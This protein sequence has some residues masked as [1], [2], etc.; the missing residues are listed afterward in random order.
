MLV[1]LLKNILNFESYKKYFTDILKIL[2]NFSVPYLLFRISIFTSGNILND[3]QVGEYKQFTWI[4]DFILGKDTIY[5]GITTGWYCQKIPN[6]LLCYFIDNIKTIIY[7]S[8]IIILI[9][10]LRKDANLSKLSFDKFR[11]I[12]LNFLLFYLFWM[13]IG[14]YPPVRFSFYSIG[15][16]VIILFT[17]LFFSMSDRYVKNTSLLIYSYFFLLINHW[18]SPKILEFT[19]INTVVLVFLFGF[20]F[21]KSRNFKIFSK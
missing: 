19:I 6:F 17:T 21:F 18:N 20:L 3:N 4:L 14:W 9:L 7:L 2:S 16:L 10:I 11:P 8:T 1:I 15:N 13:F 5:S 12:I